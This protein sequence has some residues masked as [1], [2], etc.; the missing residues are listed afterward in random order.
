MIL[1]QPSVQLIMLS[2]TLDHPEFFAEWIG[3][4]KQ[5][6]CHLIQTQ[7]RVVPLTHSVF[8][9]EKLAT[10]MGPNEVFQDGV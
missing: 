4:L 2:A 5:T 3:E 8:L 1:L 7:H 9:G 10:I 6:P